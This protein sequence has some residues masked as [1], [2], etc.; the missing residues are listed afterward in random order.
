MDSCDALRVMVDVSPLSHR[1]IADSIGR[2]PA[3]VSAT[4]SRGGVVGLDVLAAVARATGARITLTLSDGTALDLTDA[5]ADAW[6]KPQDRAR[7]WR[8]ARAQ[9]DR[10]SDAPAASAEEGTA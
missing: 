6:G 10:A 5:G 2:S 7:A 3:Y 8:E 1:A 9:P 4:I